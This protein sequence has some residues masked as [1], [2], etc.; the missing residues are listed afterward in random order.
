[1]LDDNIMGEV[2]LILCI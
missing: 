2:M 1:M